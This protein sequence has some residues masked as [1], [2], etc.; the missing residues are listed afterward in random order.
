MLPTHKLPLSKAILYIFLSIFIFSG[1]PMLIVNLIQ[2]KKEERKKDLQYSIS[3]IEQTGPVKEALKSEH[4]EE[5]L[6]LCCDRPQNLFA[7]DVKKGEELLLNSHVIKEVKI[8]KEFPNTLVVDYKAREPIAFISDYEN[9]VIDQTGTL[10]PLFPYY[11]PKVLPNVYLG[12]EIEPFSYGKIE[13][14]KWDIASNIIS[15]FNE[16]TFKGLRLR[17]IDV[18]KVR[19]KSLGKREIILTLYDKLGQK[20]YVRYLRLSKD[21]YIEEIEH[22]ISLK[23]MSLAGDII[24]DLRLL[25]NAYLMPVSEAIP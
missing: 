24:V 3:F 15:Y 12:I 8:S 1:V 22:F 19:A 23:Q 10:F 14:E 21:K 4:L 13:D 16:H 25:P 7:Y 18:S 11:T 5:L 20:E 9:V 6:Q 2:E 17:K